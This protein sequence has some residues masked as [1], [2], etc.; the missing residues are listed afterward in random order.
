MTETITAVDVTRLASVL[1][2]VRHGSRIWLHI[3]TSREFDGVMR[4]LTDEAD[5]G[6]HGSWTD[7][8][9]REKFVRISATFEHWVR[10]SELIDG[11]ANDTVHIEDV[12]W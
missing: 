12:T 10:V 4:H 7:G 1:E 9:L 2:G 5:T 6:N 8:D 11:L 3:G